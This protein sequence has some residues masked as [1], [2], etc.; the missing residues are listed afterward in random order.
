MEGG[1][2]HSKSRAG[3]SRALSVRGARGGR[4]LPGWSVRRVAPPTA[5]LD[6][7]PASTRA[8]PL[9]SAPELR[10]SA[11]QRGLGLASP[12]PSGPQAP[13]SS[14]LPLSRPPPFVLSSAARARAPRSPAPCRAAR[15]R[16]GGGE[17]GRG[18]PCAALPPAG[19]GSR[20]APAPP[21]QPP[22]WGAA[23]RRRER[24][25]RPGAGGRA[26]FP[27][28]W[29]AVGPRRAPPRRRAPSPRRRPPARG[30]HSKRRG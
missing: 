1:P 10:R 22:A 28:Q 4:A 11:R 20:P 17:G 24:E 23:L 18:R 5:S 6:W 26:R 19:P 14:R 7:L 2:R 15:R 27:P 30:C 13:P 29:A 9:P 8:L 16:A 21:P 12:R 25:G 3:A